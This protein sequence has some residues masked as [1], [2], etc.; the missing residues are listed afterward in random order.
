[1][2]IPPPGF[3]TPP[4]R[5]LNQKKSLPPQAHLLFNHVSEEIFNIILVPLIQGPL[6]QAV[7]AARQSQELIDS[8]KRSMDSL[9]RSIDQ[10][11][12]ALE[13][14]RVANP[15]KSDE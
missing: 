11:T 14:I 3:V 8:L 6:I 12:A 10:V 4:N 15:K 7:R 9:R 1:M 5:L 2:S 13:R